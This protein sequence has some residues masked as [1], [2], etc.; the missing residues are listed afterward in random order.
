MSDKCSLE[1]LQE[2]LF[3]LLQRVERL[4]GTHEELRRQIIPPGILYPKRTERE[5]LEARIARL[6]KQSEPGRA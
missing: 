5:V 3:R 2:L 6:E 1:K 4:E